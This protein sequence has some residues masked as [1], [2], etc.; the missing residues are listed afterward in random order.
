[1]VRTPVVISPDV[2]DSCTSHCNM[3]GAYISWYF[4]RLGF[5]QAM[6]FLLVEF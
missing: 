5:V 2:E 1:M 3:A 6:H 4:C